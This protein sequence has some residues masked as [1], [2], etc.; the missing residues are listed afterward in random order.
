LTD[1]LKVPPVRVVVDYWQASIKVGNVKQSHAKDKGSD[2]APSSSHPRRKP[3][4]PAFTDEGS[5]VEMEDIATGRIAAGAKGKGV[6]RQATVLTKRRPKPTPKA[7]SSQ[8]LER[9][10]ILSESPR[11]EEGTSKRSRRAASVEEVEDDEEEEEEEAE[12]TVDLSGSTVQHMEVVPSEMIPRT[13]GAV[14]R[15]SFLAITT[16]DA[17]I[18]LRILLY[19]ACGEGLPPDLVLVEGWANAVLRALREVETELLLQAEELRDPQV[20]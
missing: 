17:G 13:R 4:N 7:L 9:K 1:G 6:A 16:S 19:S 2:P 3:S 10:R 14:R 12:G 18:D 20:A 5:D 8:R 11:K 15:H